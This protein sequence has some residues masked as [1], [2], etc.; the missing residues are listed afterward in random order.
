[1]YC[2]RRRLTMNTHQYDVTSI[3]GQQRPEN[4]CMA[5]WRMYSVET[6]FLWNKDPSKPPP[7]RWCGK[8]IRKQ[9]V[10]TNYLQIVIL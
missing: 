8:Q 2:N 7:V 1:M 4:I 5:I 6:Q 3:R 10:K 9:R